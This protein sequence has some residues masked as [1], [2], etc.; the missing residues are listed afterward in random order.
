MVVEGKGSDGYYPI[1]SNLPDIKQ[2]DFIKTI[3]AISGIFAVIVNDTTLGFFSVDD[4]I[5]N[6]NKAYD[7]TRKVVASF[8][9]NKPQEI[10]YSLEDFAQKNLLTWKEDNTVKG[11]YSSA[12]YVQ[13]ETIE[14]ERTAIELPFAATDMSLSR[15][16][17]PLYDYSGNETVGKMNSVEPRLLIE[18]NNTGKSKASFEGLRWDTLVNRNYESYQKIIRNP[19]V[20]SEKIEI[21]DIELKELD[22]TIPVYLGQYGRYYAIISVRAEATGICECKL[23]QLEV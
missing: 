12:L 20:V 13:D 2:V 18:V 23:L 8:K 14:V 19:I 16:F 17:I 11:D 15:A 4:I 10:S 6:R 1:I 3:A 5:S 22:V 7:W 9:E 21:S